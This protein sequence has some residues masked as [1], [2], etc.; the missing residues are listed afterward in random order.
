MKSRIATRL[1]YLALVELPP[2]HESE[3]VVPELE[4]ECDDR[5][6]ADEVDV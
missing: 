2:F 5:L 6:R 4:I 1:Q 3:Q